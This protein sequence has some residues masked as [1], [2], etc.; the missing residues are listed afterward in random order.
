MLPT[1]SAK[2]ADRLGG[3]GFFT[4]QGLPRLQCPP[5]S[6]G[7][8]AHHVPSHQ[9]PFHLVAHDGQILSAAKLGHTI[10]D[11]LAL[12]E[13]ALLLFQHKSSTT[14]LIMQERII[15]WSISCFVL[16]L[17][18]PLP[19]PYHPLPNPRND[20]RFIA[21]AIMTKTPQEKKP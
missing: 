8:A 3:K 18:R 16:A 11:L 21:M 20:Y 15:K 19:R 6:P 5:P 2:P 7:P 4:D 13:Y 9:Q 12:C 17:F 10:N 14:E 1:H